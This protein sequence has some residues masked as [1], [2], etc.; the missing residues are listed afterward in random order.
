MTIITVAGIEWPKPGKKT[1]AIIDQSGKKWVVYADK[2]NQFQQFQSYDVSPKTISF[3][4]RSFD[5]IE[6]AA[7]MG[8]QQPPNPGPTPP[9]HVAGMPALQSYTYE[10]RKDDQRRMDIFVCGAFNNIM[11]NPTVPSHTFNS[12]DHIAIITELKKAWAATLGP[13]R[14]PIS[15][16]NSDMNDDI[17]F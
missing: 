14:D 11:A 10:Q 17:P 5:T 1:G 2:I 16:G 7:P 13:K 6:S 12:A 3:N 15:T 9:V 4:G 8:Q